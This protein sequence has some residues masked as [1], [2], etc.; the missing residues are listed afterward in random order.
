MPQT[1]E[2]YMAQAIALSREAYNRGDW[3]VASLIVRDDAIIGS[4]QNRQIT[5][6]DVTWH[7][8]TDAIRDAMSRL[9]NTDLSGAVLYAP[10]EPCPMCAWAIRASGIRTLVVGL[11]HATIKRTDMGEYNLERF[12]DMVHWKFEMVCGVMEEDY[13]SLRVEWMEQQRRKLS[14]A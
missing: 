8:E 14:A 4:G 11:R 1:H 9:D 7:A 13:K 3:P 2:H 10:M 12:A 5:R 6:N